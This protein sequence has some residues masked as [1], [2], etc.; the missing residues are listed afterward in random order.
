MAKLQKIL[1]IRLSSIGDI[2]LASPVFRCIKQQLPDVELH[3]VTKERFKAVTQA[4]PY[5]DRF[6]YLKEDLNELLEEL[7]KEQFDFVVDLHN[8][9][10][11]A[12]IKRALKAPSST[13]KKLSVQKFL[14]TK[15]GIN[16]MPKQ[17]ITKR[18]LMA[19]APLG[20][21]DDGKGLDYFLSPEDEVP[22]NDIPASHQLGY[23][24]IVIGAN[25]YTKKLPVEQ[26]QKL[27]SLI[28]YPI[29]LLGGPT[30][31]KEAEAIASVDPIKIYNATTKFTLNE[32]ADLIRKAKLIVSHDTGMQYMA[33]AYQKPIIAV[34]GGTSPK[35]QV[36]PYYGSANQSLHEN[37]YLDLKC[38]PCSKYGTARCP[39]GH[40]NCMKKL[41]MELLAAKVHQRLHIN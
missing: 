37:F 25:H 31:G 9:I 35:L 1:V 16:I 4:N 10:R 29:I 7:K 13:I 27:C 14:L 23:I 12:R 20:V 18:S 38:Q 22:F 8:N 3:F 21:K 36:E 32:C 2:I 24:G 5:I 11:S 26:L 40:F 33:C 30:E 15:L 34:W 6:H 19:A 17:H 28:N 39:K 41:D